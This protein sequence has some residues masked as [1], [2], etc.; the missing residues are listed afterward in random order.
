MFIFSYEMWYIFIHLH[1]PKCPGLE[2]WHQG[3]RFW[4]WICPI[5]AVSTW[6]KPFISLNLTFRTEKDQKRGKWD[7]LWTLRHYVI[8]ICY[9]TNIISKNILGND[10]IKEYQSQLFWQIVKNLDY[11]LLVIV[12]V[13]LL[14]PLQDFNIMTVSYFLHLLWNCQLL[15]SNY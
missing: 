15:I 2:T 7:T 6:A 4:L 1:F 13:K 12:T 11:F 10:R 5:E 8:S 3:L 14:F 9:M